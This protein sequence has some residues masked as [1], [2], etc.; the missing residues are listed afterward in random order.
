MVNQI[1]EYNIFEPA[2]L[3]HSIVEEIGGDDF[4]G[5]DLLQ[6]YNNIS[7]YDEI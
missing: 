3:V 6:V 5:S 7:Y 2:T 1:F 4:G